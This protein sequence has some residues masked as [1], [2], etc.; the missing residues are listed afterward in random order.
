M[1]RFVLKI[2]LDSFYNLIV[3]TLPLYTVLVLVGYVF[4]K[5]NLVNYQISSIQTV[6]TAFATYAQHVSVS[7]HLP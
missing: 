6:C 4:V 5:A 3:S 1:H 2:N 7:R